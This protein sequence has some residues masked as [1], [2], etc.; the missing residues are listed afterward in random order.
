MGSGRHFED[1]LENTQAMWT[2]IPNLSTQSN[3][4]LFGEVF[5]IQEHW[6]SEPQNNWSVR[7]GRAGSPQ[8][9][10]SSK[11]VVLRVEI[12]YLG[13][14][15]LDSEVENSHCPWV[16]KISWQQ[17]TLLRLAINSFLRR[18]KHKARIPVLHG[19]VFL[20]DMPNLLKNSD[21]VF[22]ALT[23]WFQSYEQRKT[24]QLTTR[25]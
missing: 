20:L 11:E 10:W 12:L 16:V 15:I 19:Q 2:L 5:Q 23:K 7:K 25:A 8:K 14:K 22:S 13:Y 3:G 21:Q 4:L 6:T 18:Q 17:E 1:S 24:H 9:K